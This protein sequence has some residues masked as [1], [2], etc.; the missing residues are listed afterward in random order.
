M[1]SQKQLTCHQ[2]KS[3]FILVAK[4]LT[5]AV[6][7]RRSMGGVRNSRLYPPFYGQIM[8]LLTRINEKSIAEFS[9][10]SMARDWNL[11]AANASLKGA[12]MIHLLT[13]KQNRQ[14]LACNSIGDQSKI[15]AGWTTEQQA[16][17]KTKR[18][19][20]ISGIVSQL[21][22]GTRFQTYKFIQIKSATHR[23]NLKYCLSCIL[24]MCLC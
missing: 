9:D 15:K 13:S 18:E 6:W 23:R 4:S 24:K 17:N 5:C 14:T 7:S 16:H 12:S 22:K 21:L 20:F 3:I 1:F 19:F 2:L 11:V 10:A 8:Q